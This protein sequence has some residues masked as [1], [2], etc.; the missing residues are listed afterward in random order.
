MYFQLSAVRLWR[1]LPSC[2]GGGWSEPVKTLHPVHL[3]TCELQAC[4]G[5]G[6]RSINHAPA[7]Y[8]CVQSYYTQAC[9][10]I[11]RL[12]IKM[13]A[14]Q[15]L[16]CTQLN[17][18]L[19]IVVTWPFIGVWTML[20]AQCR[21]H[22]R[23]FELCSIYCVWLRHWFLPS[24]PPLLH[25]PHGRHRQRSCSVRMCSVRQLTVPTRSRLGNVALC[26]SSLVS[27]SFTITARSSG[28]QV[29]TKACITLFSVV[30]WKFKRPSLSLLYGDRFALCLWSVYF[31]SA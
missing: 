3:P 20:V 22:A 2:R 28:Q 26:A 19:Y 8:W 13:H 6:R 31:L 12:A 11:P 4:W 16:I 24:H 21:C 29:Y 14:P 7:A 1:S 9:M 5:R 27:W 23:G 30:L 17:S 15:A 18:V 10:R 25:P